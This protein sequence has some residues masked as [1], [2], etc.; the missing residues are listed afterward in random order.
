MKKNVNPAKGMRDF[1]PKEKETRNFVENKISETYK[2]S[3]FELIETPSVENLENLMGSEGGDNIKLIYKIMKRGD[4]FNKAKGKENAIENDFADMGL[5]YDLTVPLSRFY[6]NNKANLPSVFKAMQIGYVFR[7]ERAQKGRYRSFKQ[8]DI[9]IIGESSN[10]AEIELITTTSKALKA[11]NVDKFK[12]RINDRRILRAVILNAG[13]EENQFENVCVIVDKLDKVGFEGVENELNKSEYSEDAIKSLIQALGKINEDGI[14]CLATYGVDEE[15]V[16]WIK[17]IMTK[18]DKALKNTVCVEFDFTLVRGMGYYTGTIFEI[19]YEGLGYAI[20]GGGRYDKMVGN[21]IGQDIPAVGFSIGFERLVNQMIEENY[22][23]PG[24]GKIALLYDKEND[25]ADV[26][27]Y[28]DEIREQGYRVALFEKAKK[29]GK[30]LSKLQDF[31]FNRFVV[32]GEGHIK[33]I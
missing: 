9:D 6:C 24:L 17:D 29:M 32:F 22:E 30:Q 18:V 15:V 10:A 19:Q 3:G 1:L 13:F 16:I 12:I 27:M 11:L 21:F 33:E 25:F 8:C 31:G 4:K 14:D 23:I 20:G 2:N 28:A 26:M 5:R 7:A